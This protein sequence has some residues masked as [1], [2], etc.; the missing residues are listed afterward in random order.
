[1]YSL[2]ALSSFSSIYYLL[3]TDQ[4]NKLE[5]LVMWSVAPELMTHVEEEEIKHVLVLPNS[6]RVQIEVDAD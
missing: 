3:F 4:K 1:M 5:L 2:G 6:T